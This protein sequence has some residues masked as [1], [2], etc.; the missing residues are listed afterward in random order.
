MALE[1]SLVFAIPAGLINLLKALGWAILFYIIF[2][3]INLVVNRKKRNELKKINN[4][5]ED[6]KKLLAKKKK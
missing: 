6:I 3:T 4:N 5:L 1:D 2:N